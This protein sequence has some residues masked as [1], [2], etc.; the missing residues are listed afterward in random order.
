MRLHGDHRFDFEHDGIPHT[1]FREGSGP[2][3]LVM[4]EAPGMSD[5]CLALGDRLI[6]AGFSAYLPLFFGE[7][8]MDNNWSAQRLRSCAFANS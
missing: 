5:R 6:G 4:R 2:G 3:V 7:P 8:G 1:V